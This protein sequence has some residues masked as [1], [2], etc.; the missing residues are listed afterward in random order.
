MTVAFEPPIPILRIFSLEKAREFY[1]D[2]LGFKLD[3][4]HTFEPGAP[5]YMQVSR[6]NVRLHLS[7]HHGDSVPG[8]AVYVYMNGIDEL[9]RELNDKKYRHMRPGIVEQEWRMRELGV[10]D[11]FGNRIRFG[12]RMT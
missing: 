4:E 8:S 11:P 7:E 12:E 1:L 6:D 2:F 3:W 9:H 5:V 10:I